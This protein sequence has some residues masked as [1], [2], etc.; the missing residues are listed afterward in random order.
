MNASLSATGLGALL[1][2]ACSLAF[3]QAT[4][5]ISQQGSA[6]TAYTEQTFGSPPPEIPGVLTATI[7]QIGNNNHVG[8]ALT[9]TPRIF[10][11][12]AIRTVATATVRQH[13]NQNAASISQ[14]VTFEEVPVQ[15]WQI[16][17]K[18]TAAISQLQVQHSEAELKQTG[19]DNVASVDQQGVI[20]SG[21]R[22][23]QDGSGNRLSMRQQRSSLGRP[24]ITQ[25][26][27]ANSVTFE[28]DGVFPAGINTERKLDV[29]PALNDGDSYS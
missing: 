14:D 10:Q 2:C 9:R 11:R 22:I 15:I 12:S 3:A 6:N 19:N 25:T 24:S 23:S 17:N 26:G 1:T 5:T 18:N 27:T 4:T 21:F 16:G 8:D 7:E 13:G 29:L 20:D 28:Q